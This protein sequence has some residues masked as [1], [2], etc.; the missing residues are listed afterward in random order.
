M[1]AIKSV[2]KVVK[3][4][5]RVL[6][7]M[8]DIKNYSSANIPPYLL[9]EFQKTL[10]SI[11]KEKPQYVVAVFPTIEDEKD[12]LMYENFYEYEIQSI[13]NVSIFHN[14]SFKKYIK[15]DKLY[16]L[17]V[18]DI[19]EFLYN[20]TTNDMD[21][22]LVD[23]LYLNDEYMQIVKDNE[24][25][26]AHGKCYI[27]D[28]LNAKM[29][30]KK[31]FNKLMKPLYSGG[32]HQN[33]EE[34]DTDVALIIGNDSKINQKQLEHILYELMKRNQLALFITTDDTI[35]NMVKNIIIKLKIRL[36]I[37]KIN[38]PF[39]KNSIDEFYKFLKRVAISYTTY[40]CIGEFNFDS[41]DTRQIWDSKKDFL[42]GNC[43]CDAIALYTL[44][45]EE[46][47]FEKTK[48]RFTH[49]PLGMLHL[50][51]NMEDDFVIDLKP[52]YED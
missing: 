25:Q 7:F 5:D 49:N 23:N 6:I 30:L 16:T 38:M 2:W 17:V 20:L 36:R 13:E 4:D 51:L 52:A 9:K 46:K 27:D 3:K 1:F 37:Y 19:E 34:E 18:E 40:V 31:A 41:K 22:V 44:F 29:Y 50:F 28:F 45:P 11:F 32:M 10:H 42:Q 12:Y 48:Y 33:V 35:Y 47:E 21:L 15:K 43:I 24:I 39:T 14:E 26:C 8:P